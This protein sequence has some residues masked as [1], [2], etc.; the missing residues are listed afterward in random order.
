V[1]AIVDA[2]VAIKWFVPEGDH[3]PAERLRLGRF[4]L[5]A[6]ELMKVEVAYA[7]WKKRRQEEIDDRD[8]HLI[9][10]A[11]SAGAVR[12]VSDG[13]LFEEAFRIACDIDHPVYDCLYLALAKAER[14]KVVTADTRLLDKAG[15]SGLG[16]LVQPLSAI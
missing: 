15:R 7:L 1:K 4:S 10:R 8:C 6:P 16:R 13:D 11:L 5:V 3:E 14:G 12:Y 9:L 2:S